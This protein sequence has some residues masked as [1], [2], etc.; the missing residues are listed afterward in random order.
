MRTGM[1][2]RDNASNG[3]RIRDP[4]PFYFSLQDFGFQKGLPFFPFPLFLSIGLPCLSSVLHGVKIGFSVLTDFILDSGDGLFQ[5][6]LLQLTFPDND[7]VPSLSLQL[8]PN[9]LISLLISGY[10]GCPKLSISLWR[11]GLFTV[12]MPMPKTA[13]YE[14]GSSVL[15]ENYIGSTR[16]MFDIHTVAKT[17]TP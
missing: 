13:M 17:R 12:F 1:E 7:N 10:F 9:F 3:V 14:D 8:P 16:K 5:N 15:C 6:A 11:T 4:V 2:Y